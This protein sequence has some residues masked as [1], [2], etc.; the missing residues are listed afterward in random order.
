M[1]EPENWRWIWLLTTGFFLVGEMLTPG[2]F[3]LLPFAAGALVA[4]V[5][6]FAG[7]GLVLQW[8]LFLVVSAAASF[9]FIPLRNRLDDVEPTDGIGSRRMINQEGVVLRAISPGADGIGLVR[10]GREE[11]RAESANRAGIPEGAT[12]CV[13]DV[14]GTGVVVMPARSTTEG[15]IT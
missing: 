3:I 15:T 1:G 8:L 6:A 12:V 10:V 7:A 11:W 2:S 5:S 4:M 13:V 14:K 9:A